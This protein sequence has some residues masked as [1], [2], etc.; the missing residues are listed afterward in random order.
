MIGDVCSCRI[1][2]LLVLINSQ[3]VKNRHDN[4]QLVNSENWSL[5]LSVT[6][7]F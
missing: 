6:K 2:A 4:K 7:V 3:Y 5:Y 1:C